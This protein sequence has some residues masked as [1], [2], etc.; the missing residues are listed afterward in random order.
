[1]LLE[2]NP[3]HWCY[4]LQFRGQLTKRR[5]GECPPQTE[6]PSM[7]EIIC[8]CACNFCAIKSTTILCFIWHLFVRPGMFEELCKGDNSLSCLIVNAKIPCHAAKSVARHF[9]T[10]VS[11]GPLLVRG[12][13]TYEH[14]IFGITRFN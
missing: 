12:A 7:T 5:F 11:N 1:M 6:L 8:V 10:R 2:F 4:W 9:D 13:N 3:S 14:T